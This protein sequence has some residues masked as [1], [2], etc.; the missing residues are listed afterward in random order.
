MN[1]PFPVDPPYVPDHAVGC[2]RQTF[3]VPAGWSEQR[4]RLT[5]DGVCSAFTVWVNG[6]EA[7]FSKVSHVPAEFD[8]SDLVREGENT[9]AVQVHQWSDA[10]YLEDQPMW[11]H[12]GIFRDVWLLRCRRRTSTTS[13][14]VGC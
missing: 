11:R 9:L 8:I 4:I 10:S 6:E 12:N 14:P 5:F 2:Y 13:K 3:A 7:G 1:Y